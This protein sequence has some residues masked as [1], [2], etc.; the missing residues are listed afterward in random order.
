LSSEQERSEVARTLLFSFVALIA[1]L[2]ILFFDKMAAYYNEH[3][4]HY[5]IALAQMMLWLDRWSFVVPIAGFFCATRFG[6][7]HLVRSRVL[8]SVV[9]DLLAAFAGVWTLVAIL[10]WQLQ[11]MSW[12]IRD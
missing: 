5:L 11:Q 6:R 7:K 10:I 12:I 9:P 2:C 8:M 4:R 3:E 1:C